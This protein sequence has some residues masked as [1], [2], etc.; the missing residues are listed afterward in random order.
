MKKNFF[1]T[2]GGLVLSLAV[3]G[4]TVW[5]ASMAWKKGQEDKKTA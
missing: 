3:L 5:V 1:T 4:V 2:A